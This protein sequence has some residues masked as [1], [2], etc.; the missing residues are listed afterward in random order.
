MSSDSLCG[1]ISEHQD[2]DSPIIS[3]VIFEKRNEKLWENKKRRM[4]RRLTPL[5][6][7]LSLPILNTVLNEKLAPISEVETYFE[8][9]FE[10]IEKTRK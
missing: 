10:R 2:V 8:S 9:D 3:K 1:S 7:T 6:R 5:P 4:T